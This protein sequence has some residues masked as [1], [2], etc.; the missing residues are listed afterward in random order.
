MRICTDRESSARKAGGLMLDY[1]PDGQINFT[2][3]FQKPKV[4]IKPKSLVD[5]INGM[6]TAQ[7][8]QIG[9]VITKSVESNGYN[10][11]SEEIDRITNS[12]SVWLLNIGE[13]YDLH[14]R[15]LLNGE[16]S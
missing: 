8:T 13:A 16:V 10:I 1:I 12:V 5:F 4:D 6:G 14:L 9:N 7:Y 3:Y 2:D 11:T 15:N